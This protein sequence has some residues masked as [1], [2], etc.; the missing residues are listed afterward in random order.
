LMFLVM[1]L[2]AS[3][4]GAPGDH[5]PEPSAPSLGGTTGS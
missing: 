1:I 2:M 3:A 5:E 4:H